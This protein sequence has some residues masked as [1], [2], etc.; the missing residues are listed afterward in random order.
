MGEAGLPVVG[1]TLPFMQ[2][3]LPLARRFHAKYGEVFWSNVLGTKLVLVLG[4]DGLETVLTNR[5]RAFAN[6]EGWEHFIGP[7]FHRGVMLMDFE[8]HRHHRRIMQQAFK[9]DRLVAYLDKMNPA[10]QRGIATWPTGPGFE[11]YTATKQLTLNVAT[12]VFMGAE[13]GAQAD[14]LDHASST[15]SSAARRS[16]APTFAAASGTAVLRAAS[17]CSAG[18]ASRSPPSAP[19]TATTCSASSA[20]PRPR[21]RALLRRGR[22]QPHDL[23][24]DGRPR[25][26]HD[27]AGDDGLLPR[28]PP[29]WQSQCATSRGHSATSLTTLGLNAHAATLSQPQ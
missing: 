8:E 25:H 20:T 28:P 17:Y 2:H 22:R 1:Q 9:R 21:R 12:E 24:D 6:K 18:S 10:I 26:Q 19:A 4:P 15:P 16:S 29:Q 5:D 7:F 3:T 11:L 27:H 14:S 13:L 23:H